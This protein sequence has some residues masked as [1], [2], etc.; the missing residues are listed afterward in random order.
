MLW[1]PGLGTAA[2]LGVCYP[3]LLPL[4]RLAR[5]VAAASGP[6]VAGGRA[7][8]VKRRGRGLLL[9]GPTAATCTCASLGE[10]YLVFLGVGIRAVCSLHS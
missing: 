4:R 7:A 10:S 6:G 9:M 3:S 8:G 1:L 5:L 2:G